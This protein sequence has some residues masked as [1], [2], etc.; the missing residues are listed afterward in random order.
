MAVPADAVEPDRACGRV[1]R[2]GRDAGGRARPGAG[3][4][5][6]GCGLT[7]VFAV[8]LTVGA[9]FSPWL[10]PLRDLAEEAERVCGQATTAN[11]CRWFKTTISARSRRRST[12]RR[13]DW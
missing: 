9:S 6:I 3:R 4:P 13:R 5:V 11:A 12:A 2:R 7:L 8:P 10:Q 1:R